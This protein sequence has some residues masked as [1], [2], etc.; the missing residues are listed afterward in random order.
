[1][2]RADL[3]GE[4]VLDRPAFRVALDQ[5][6]GGTFALVGEE[7]GGLVA[8]MFLIAIWRTEAVTPLYSSEVQQ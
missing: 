8:P 4:F 7:Q 5:L 2:K 1:M 3:R 6:F